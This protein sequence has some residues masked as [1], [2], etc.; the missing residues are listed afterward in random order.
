MPP[1]AQSKPA[2]TPSTPPA[3]KRP[4]WMRWLLR[5]LAW[6]MGLAVAGALALALVIAVALAMA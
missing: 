1:P 2:G 6:L 3:S 4:S 5:S